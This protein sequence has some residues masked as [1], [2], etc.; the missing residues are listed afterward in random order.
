MGRI[1]MRAGRQIAHLPGA[2]HVAIKLRNQCNLLIANALTEGREPRHWLNGE[3]D[4]IRCAGPT[5][6]TFV[7]VG[8]NVGV[9]T[10]HLLD[11]APLQPAGA[12]V[13]PSAQSARRL[14][15]RFAHAPNVEVVE[16]AA[17][18]GNSGATIS[19]FE[20]DDCG[21]NSS[22][23]PS[24]SRY[25]RTQRV[26]PVVTVADVVNNRG[27]QRVDLLKIDTEGFD[28]HVLRGAAPLFHQQR[29][30]AVQFEY[31]YAWT[32][33]RSTLAEALNLLEGYG[34]SV[35]ILTGTGLHPFVYEPCQEYFSATNF[36]GLAP[37]SH[38][39]FDAMLVRER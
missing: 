15:D 28:L 27:W 5:C 6:T 1:L 38:E 2:A 25:P 3:F 8:A 31:S 21:E 9:W 24:V 7:D 32:Q 39:L 17:G 22:V 19:F 16:A 18:D 14:R 10:Q 30:L 20:E 37:D 34:Y 36:V 11:A 35:Y 26:V 13:E 4:L 33:A 23:L 12:L 29:V